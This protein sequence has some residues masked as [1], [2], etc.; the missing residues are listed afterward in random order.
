M[1]SRQSLLRNAV[2]L[3]DEPLLLLL[4]LPSPL[5]LLPLLLLPLLLLLLLLLLPLGEQP[6]E[7]LEEPPDSDGGDSDKD[8]QEDAD[9]VLIADDEQELFE[10]DT[11][12]FSFSGSIFS[13]FS[14]CIYCF[15][16]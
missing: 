1:T 4:L 14:F 7:P 6:D 10:G 16:A 12:S 9:E 13:D 11:F 5:L 2:T 8:S 15:S 3:D